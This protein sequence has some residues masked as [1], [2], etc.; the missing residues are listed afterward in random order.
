VAEQG[1]AHPSTTAAI[2]ATGRRLRERGAE[3]LVLACGGMA[4]TSR[5]VAAALDL[6]VVDGVGFGAM[7]AYGLWR[8]DLRTSKTGAYGW[9]EPI[10]YA[11]MPGFARP[12]G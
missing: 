7:L 9:P 5:E 12:A 6:P 3:A 1:A 4:D 11:G 2:V 10:P 8:C